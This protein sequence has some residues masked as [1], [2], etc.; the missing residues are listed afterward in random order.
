MFTV[1]NEQMLQGVKKGGWS[2]QWSPPEMSNFDPGFNHDGLY[3]TAQ[4][5]H[6][7]LA[8]NKNLL[9]EADA[10]KQW[11]DLLDPRFKGQVGMTSPWRTVTNSRLMYF[12]ENK[13]G[14][15]NLAERMKENEVR[16]F[17]GSGGVYQALLRGDIKVAEI[18]DLINPMLAEGAPI[19][20]LYPKEGT[21]MNEHVLFLAKDAPHPNAAK[22]FLNWLL[23]ENGQAALQNYGGMISARKGSVAPSNLPSNSEIPNLVMG[24]TLLGED[25][26]QI[27]VNH[28]REVFGQ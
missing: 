22:I 23:S 17:E 2:L 9:S 27:I 10:P 6:E 28:W 5:S 7:V 18:S 1:T 20:V 13:L 4:T 12:I 8:W 19:G 14:I 16:F 15:K 26:R 24:E 3:F 11:A 21:I 25:Q